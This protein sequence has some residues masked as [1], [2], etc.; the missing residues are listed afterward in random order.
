MVDVCSML[1]GEYE[2]TVILPAG[3]KALEERFLTAGASKVAR[4]HGQCRLFCYYSG[5]CDLLTRSFAKRII[6][7]GGADREI[8]QIVREVKPDIFIANS[9]VQFPLGRLLKGQDCK[10]ILYIRETFRENPVSRYMIRKINR[11]FDGVLAIS[12]YELQYAGFKIRTQVVA[13]CYSCDAASFQDRY[14][15]NPSYT[16]FL[17]LGG[18]SALKGF[19]TLIRALE[20]ANET[21]FRLYIGGSIDK[22]AIS[23]ELRRIID[24][25]AEKI[26]WLGF[27]DGVE[28]I[29]PFMDAIV[30]PSS[31][32]HQPRP[33]MEAGY[34]GKTAILSDFPQTAAFYQNDVN[35]LTFTP[36]DPKAL[37]MAID[38][39]TDDSRLRQRLS[40]KNRDMTL[41]RHS[42]SVER[43]TLLDYCNKFADEV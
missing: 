16:N 34:F 6:G 42:M 3:E 9:V 20:Y 36:N 28:T 43:G 12:P 7:S 10:K 13:D 14:W 37:A 5:S 31:K 4:Y 11:Y 15:V 27:I 24:R 41:T 1:K 22:S 39:L 40:D 25:H 18:T 35:C 19:P 33:V 2:I 23:A 38:R 29:M 32:P 26:V 8:R 21:R 30:F 17:Y